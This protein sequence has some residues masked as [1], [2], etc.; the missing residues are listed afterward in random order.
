M[1]KNHKSKKWGFH[2]W[3]FRI[4]IIYWK[5]ACVLFWFICCIANVTSLW[6]RKLTFYF[7]NT[8]GARG[9]FIFDLTQSAKYPIIFYIILSWKMIILTKGC[10]SKLWPFCS[11]QQIATRMVIQYG[12]GPDDSPAIYYR[13]NAVYRPHVH[14]NYLFFFLMLIVWSLKSLIDLFDRFKLTFNIAHH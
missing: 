4:Q 11:L 3:E 1:Y 7:W 5:E 8:A 9:W 10:K 2:Q 13:S 14:F 12:W 6:G